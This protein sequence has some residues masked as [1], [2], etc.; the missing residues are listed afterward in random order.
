MR[1][2]KVYGA[3]LWVQAC[4]PAPNGNRQAR[5]IVA[6]RSMADAAR[7]F[8]HTASAIRNH[9]CKTGNAE[10]IRIATAHPGVALWRPLYEHRG[11]WTRLKP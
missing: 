1:T 2:V 5:V 7:A 8:G 10:E 3:T 11:E 9:C 6:A 4:P